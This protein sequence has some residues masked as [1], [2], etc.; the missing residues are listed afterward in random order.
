MN[1]NSICKCVYV[2]IAIPNRFHYKQEKM[3]SANA[4]S[5]TFTFLPGILTLFFFLDWHRQSKST[6][7]SY[8]CNSRLGNARFCQFST[9]NP[10]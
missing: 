2:L 7:I 4:W 9:G 3:L 1:T 8:H 10:L 5:L 6:A